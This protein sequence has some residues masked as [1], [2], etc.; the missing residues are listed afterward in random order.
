MIF[1]DEGDVVVIRGFETGLD[2]A[3]DAVKS[4][5]GGEVGATL[6][7]EHAAV[8]AIEC[9]C[10]LNPLNFL[11]DFGIDV[12]AREVWGAAK[13]RHLEAVR[14]EARTDIGNP[15]G[16]GFHKASVELKAIHAEGRCQLNPLRDGHGF[17]DA[18]LIHIAF[19]KRGDT[20]LV[21]GGGCP[22]GWMLSRC[23][24]R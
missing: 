24:Q 4:L 9:G 2:G 10:Q 7:G 15:S 14:I 16:V 5:F 19:W 6:S 13:H 11:G 21:H 22:V 18:E 3:C 23:I 12:V 8:F 1:E 17:V 20:G